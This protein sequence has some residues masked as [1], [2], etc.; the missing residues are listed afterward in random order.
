MFNLNGTVVI[1][2]PSLILYT[3]IHVQKFQNDF[4]IPFSNP[5]YNK[6]LVTQSCL[7]LCDPMDCSPAG[8]SVHGIFP[9]KNTRVGCHFPL[10][11]THTGGQKYLTVSRV[12]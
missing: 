2:F 12:Y 4:N 7:T 6:V 9:G 11:G 3:N 5:N 10:Q 1:I 8:S